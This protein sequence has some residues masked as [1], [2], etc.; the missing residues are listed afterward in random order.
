MT[1]EQRLHAEHI[2]ERFK[3]R[4]I[5][6]YERGALEHGGNI[7]QLDKEDLIRMATEEI[8]DLAVYIGT[9]EDK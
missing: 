1:E 5:K 2:G 9:L 7:W 8:I 4:L 3:Q 6:K